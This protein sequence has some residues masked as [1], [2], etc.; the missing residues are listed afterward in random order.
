MIDLMNA[1]QP[2]WFCLEPSVVATPSPSPQYSVCQA[3]LGAIPV[4]EASQE[5]A[6]IPA[7]DDPLWGAEGPT[8]HT[9]EITLDIDT[10]RLVDEVVADEGW[11][12]QH[13]R[14]DVFRIALYSWFDRVGIA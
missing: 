5:L 13:S 14:D 10:L 4:L 12:R 3:H 8:H 11:V 7:A 6:E 1:P 2:C 9:F